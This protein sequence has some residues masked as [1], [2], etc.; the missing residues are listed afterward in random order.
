M[1]IWQYILNRTQFAR[2]IP[3]LSS[4]GE[5]YVSKCVPSAPPSPP[6]QP[7]KPQHPPRIRSLLPHSAPHEITSGVMWPKLVPKRG[8]EGENLEI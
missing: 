7:Q 2:D 1:I 4:L 6:T 8:P 3:N 5:T